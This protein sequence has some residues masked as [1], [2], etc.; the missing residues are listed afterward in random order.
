MRRRVGKGNTATGPLVK[1]APEAIAKANS[2]RRYIYI[3]FEHATYGVVE[4]TGDPITI[5]DINW[6]MMAGYTPTAYLRPRDYHRHGWYVTS[7]IYE[8]TRI[9]RL[10]RPKLAYPPRCLDTREAK[11]WRAML[12]RTFFR[13][14]VG[15]HNLRWRR[16]MF[17]GA[18]VCDRW[19]NFES[20][21]NDAKS[22]PGVGPYLCRRDTYDGFYPE[23]CYWSKRPQST[24]TKTIVV[25]RS[26][27]AESSPCQPT[28]QSDSLSP[29]VPERSSAEAEAPAPT[30]VPE[31]AENGVGG[32]IE[33]LSKSLAPAWSRIYYE[34]LVLR[35]AMYLL[36]KLKV[37]AK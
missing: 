3:R 32:R 26:K 37:K 36:A 10:P 17:S 12:Q 7:V 28:R 5:K 24:Y 34:T 8:P 2:L 13:D 25:T 23:N 15:I 16:S 31:L 29:V 6:A 21:A 1:F 20:F 22:L 19:A 18:F 35:F 9:G 14:V 33:T 4:V 27:P 11:A 30:S